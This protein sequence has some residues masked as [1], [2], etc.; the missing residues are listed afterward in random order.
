MVSVATKPEISEYYTVEINIVVDDPSSAGVTL[1]NSSGSIISS[2]TNISGFTN[3]GDKNADFE[4]IKIDGIYYSAHN[5]TTIK[6][7]HNLSRNILNVADEILDGSELYFYPKINK[8]NQIYED[9]F[10][11]SLLFEHNRYSYS[12][13][14]FS[15]DK[16]IFG[17][18]HQLIFK[19]DLGH[20][21]QYSPSLTLSIINSSGTP[22]IAVSEDNTYYWDI[23]KG[24]Q[25]GSS[26][27]YVLTKLSG[28]STFYIKL[29]CGATDS[30]DLTYMKLNS[31][32][33][34][35]GEQ[36]YIRVLANALNDVLICTLTNGQINYKFSWRDKYN[37]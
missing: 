15:T 4:Y 23:D 22:K 7:Q 6:L 3:D 9:F 14:S 28:K 34:I 26:I 11:S 10:A 17:H 13:V 29:Y 16:L 8:M 5:P 18:S 33:S 20:A 31:W 30:F 27:E 1:K 32:H 36:P 12:G 21:L 37:Y 2:P 25:N 35:S 24:L 19:F